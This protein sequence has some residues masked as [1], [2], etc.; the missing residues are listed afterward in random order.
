MKPFTF[1]ALAVSAATL[2][3]GRAAQAEG[4]SGGYIT[5]HVGGGLQRSDDGEFIGFDKNLDGDFGDTVTTV[6]G[7][8]A[9]SP[10]FC[11]GAALTPTPAGGC[12]EDG[13]KV[14]FG[15]RSGYDW[16]SGRL[17]LGV[18]GEFAK[19]GLSDNVSAFSTT[20]ARYAFS[21]RLD[22]IGAFRA[23]VGLG[24]PKALVYATGGPA[25]ARIEHSFAT[26]NG[27][28][29]F[30]P[31]DDDGV[32]G[33]Q[34]GGGLEFRF[35]G[36]WSIGTEYL[37][38]GLDDTDKY[39][40]RAQGPAPATNPFILT[41]RAGTDFRRSDKFSFQTARIAVSYRF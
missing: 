30:V 27:V 33:Y 25:Y 15:I 35:A 19:A 8:N 16:Q 5:G 29:T 34:V 13:N 18:L 23:R 20:P 37:L 17:V 6:A 22:V 1:V 38:T 40:V 21:R 2:F 7:A 26:S 24:W 3:A 14:D 4:W 32:F 10:G 28:N 36:N 12:T 11:G 9:F 39:T 31:V 41:D